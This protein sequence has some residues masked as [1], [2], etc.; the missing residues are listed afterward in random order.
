MKMTGENE[1]N[2][3]NTLSAQASLEPPT[4]PGA[5][6]FPTVRVAGRFN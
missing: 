2:Y 5:V 4:I 6:Q 1:G 3:I